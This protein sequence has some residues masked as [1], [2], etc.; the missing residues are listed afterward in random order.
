MSDSFQP[1]HHPDADQLSAFAEQALPAHERADVLSHLADCADCR[2]VVFL[3]PALTPQ[4]A[5][6]QSAPPRR[7]WFSGWTL[8]W[9]VAA[10]FAILLLTIALRH[11]ARP[12]SSSTS[13]I[14]ESPAPK[15]APPVSPPLAPPP[16]AVPEKAA[17]GRAPA[18]PEVPHTAATMAQPAGQAAPPKTLTYM[19]IQ[20]LAVTGRDTTELLKVLP[21]VSAPNQGASV[22]AGS[23]A[24]G[25]AAAPAP[26]TVANGARQPVVPEPNASATVISGDAL[27]ALSDARALGAQP[28]PSHLAA[29]SIATAG[30]RVLAMDTA[31]SVFISEDGGLHWQAVRPAW[32]GR[33]VR[34][35]LV[36][37][38]A[39]V[40][41]AATAA[42]ALNRRAAI[43]APAVEAAA[44]PPP[45][46]VPGTSLLSGIVTDPSGAS[47][48]GATV[49]V[50]NIASSVSTTLRTDASGHYAASLAAGSYR[51]QASATG[52]ATRQLSATLA[53]AQPSV[54]DITL[55]VGAVTDT[56]TVTSVAGQSLTEQSPQLTAPLRATGSKSP[57][58][59]F[60]ITTD[61]GVRWT[62]PDGEHWTR[63]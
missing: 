8:A 4:P 9:P 14:A 55:A 12:P 37:Q 44:A 40:P 63:E 19:D 28:L 17:R 31:H 46:S 58:P 49:T 5:P 35:A 56:V 57:T 42:A 27:N 21:G 2:A 32:Q 33:A 23:G 30:A 52:F 26:P 36:S 24:G 61:S 50:T 39:S 51:I 62:S 38:N 41:I 60:A 54:N 43:Q 53:A 3:A 1:G 10:A 34:V 16:P 59:V 6:P 25:M 48:S 13:Q 45:P 11:Q 20:D 15:I 47:I 29:L 18:R 7:W 22:V